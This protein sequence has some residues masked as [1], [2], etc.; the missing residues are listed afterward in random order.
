MQNAH[1]VCQ[2]LTH[3]G[4][5]HAVFFYLVTPTLPP[6][7]TCGILYQ[8]SLCPEGDTS[9]VPWQRAGVR[10]ETPTTR[11]SAPNPVTTKQQRLAAITQPEA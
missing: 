2:D 10:G 1:F 8:Y 4:F 6:P 9:L 3:P 11:P 5:R 7:P